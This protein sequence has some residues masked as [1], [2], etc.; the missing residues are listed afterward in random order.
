MVNDDVATGHTLL[1]NVE[2]V[3]QQALA[4]VMVAV[5][6][7]SLQALDH[8][9]AVAD[10]VVCLLAPPNFHAAGQ[11]YNEFTQVTDKEVVDGLHTAEPPPP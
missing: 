5:P 3:R 10:E 7:S 1:A 9:Q 11:F 4:R 6:V 2:L 8:L